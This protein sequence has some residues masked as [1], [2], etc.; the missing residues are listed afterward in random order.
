MLP[1]AHEKYQIIATRTIMYTAVTAF[2]LR[3]R[4]LDI[5]ILSP[6]KIF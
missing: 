1:E 4:N 5:E 6:F 3:V 2:I